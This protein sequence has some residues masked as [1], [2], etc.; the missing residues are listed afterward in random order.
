[1]VCRGCGL[2]YGADH[3]FCTRC[4]T[5]FKGRSRKDIN[6]IVREN[7]GV[8]PV[9]AIRGLAH[10]CENKTQMALALGISRN[11]LYKLLE[12]YRVELTR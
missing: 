1:M 10:I 3:V 7:T 11:S 5:R 8:S 12:R 6:L 9:T 4:G 2:S